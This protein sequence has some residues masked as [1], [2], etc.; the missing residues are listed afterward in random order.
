MTSHNCKLLQGGHKPNGV[1]QLRQRTASKLHCFRAW[2]LFP[3]YSICNPGRDQATEMMG[4]TKTQVQNNWTILN[5][6]CVWFAPQSSQSF[7]YFTCCAWGPLY[8]CKCCCRILIL[9]PN[10]LR[11][12][13][14]ASVRVWGLWQLWIQM[15]A[16]SF[17]G[18]SEIGSIEFCCVVFIVTV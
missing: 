11:S 10:G 6:V 4:S 9:W 1:T 13:K 17:N 18:G 2:S 14:W 12:A 16:L 8:S 15:S 3:T 7:T 5:T